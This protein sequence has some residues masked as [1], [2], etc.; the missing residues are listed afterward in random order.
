MGHRALV[1][2]ERRDG[3]YNL[4]YTHWGACNLRLKQTIATETPYGGDDPEAKWPRDVHEKLTN[5]G[6]VADV[7]EQYELENTRRD[8][9]VIPQTIGV[10]FDTAITD[11]LN[12]LSHEAL[13][14]VSSDFEVTAYRTH[15]F[16]LQYE[17]KSVTAGETVGNGALRTVRWYDSEPVGDGFVQGEFQGLKA[18][19]GD[20]VDRGV[21]SEDQALAYMETKVREWSNDGDI[22]VRRPN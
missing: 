3:Q 20:L 16:G 10:T 5:G 12:Y 9:E 2:Y 8:V 7:Q 4:H 17:S 19:V 21:F 14:V 15:W 11:H 6:S 1:A 18:V 13:Y 22:F